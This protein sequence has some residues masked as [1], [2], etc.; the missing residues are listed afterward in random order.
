VPLP[1]DYDGDGKADVCVFRPSTG[2][3]FVL[4]S[5][6]GSTSWWYRG[7]GIQAQGDVPAPGDYDGD[8][9]VD[10]CVFRP[11]TGTWL[12]LETH[13]NYTTWNWFGWGVSTDTLTPSDFDGDGITD[14]A[15]YRAS[16]GTWYVRPSSGASP[17][18][19]VF[20]QS[21]DLP[22]SWIR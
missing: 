10:L 2:T 11:G 16:T 8:G 22:L 7:W 13:A 21:G 20:G 19:V 4:T 5:T 17:W 9:K 18:N 3:W 15:V 14:G 1:G 12:I 6:S